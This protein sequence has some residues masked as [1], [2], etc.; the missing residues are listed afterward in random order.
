MGQKINPLGFRIGISKEHNAFWYAKSRKYYSLVKQDIFIRNFITEKMS[1]DLVSNILIKRKLNLVYINVYVGKA[2]NLLKG[3]GV[4]NISLDLSRL[5][6]FNFN[7]HLSSF[8]II[9]I[10][11][12]D[13]S[14]S[15]ISEFIKQQLE[16]RVPFRKI[17]KTA[18]IKVQQPF[19]K[20]IKIQI[21]GRLNGAEIART[22][23]VREGQVPLHTLRANID[24]YNGKARTIFGVLGIKVW[25]YLV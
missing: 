17:I 19:V 7:S 9:E 2:N 15:L 10:A 4:N 16:K 18:I 20:G 25:L 14:A 24:Y 11:N 22:E 23:W 3:S 6:L 1:S 13:A 21:S 12:P 8:N 5:L